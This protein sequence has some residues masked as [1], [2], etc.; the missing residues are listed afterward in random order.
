MPGP[1]LTDVAPVKLVPV[2]VTDSVWPHIP[3]TGLMAAAQTGALLKEA[4]EL[5]AMMVASRRT[6]LAGN[7]K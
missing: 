7:R 6:L 2:I 5:T 3:E 4:G 1:K